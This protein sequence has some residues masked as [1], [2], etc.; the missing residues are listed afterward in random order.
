MPATHGATC[1]LLHLC[2]YADAVAGTGAHFVIPVGTSSTGWRAAVLERA[3][4]LDVRLAPL[5]AAMKCELNGKALPEACPLGDLRGATVRCRCPG[6]LGGAP[7]GKEHHPTHAS[8]GTS[9][10]WQAPPAA[11]AAPLLP[12][13]GRGANFDAMRKDELRKAAKN[14]GIKQF[15]QSTEQLREPC[16]R[17]AQTQSPW[18]AGA[19]Q[20]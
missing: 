16:K 19:R 3:V 20:P 4:A 13:A 12:A 8:S 11:C 15:G 18:A 1:F 6:L 7:K 2:A 10:S 17:A 5:V 9:S 14:L